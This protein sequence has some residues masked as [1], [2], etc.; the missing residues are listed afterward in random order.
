M[1]DQSK[2][3]MVGTVWTGRSGYEKRNSLANNRSSCA[4]KSKGIHWQI[5]DP[6]PEHWDF[7][8]AA[9]ASICRFE[10]CSVSLKERKKL[11]TNFLPSDQ[12]DQ[13]TVLPTKPVGREKPTVYLF[14]Y[15]GMPSPRF[16]VFILK[17]LYQNRSSFSSFCVFV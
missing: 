2:V 14:C 9:L 8:K 15:Q 13:M 3:V 4:V 5:T 11:I 7:P 17:E 10:F 12:S 6:G 16:S 1:C